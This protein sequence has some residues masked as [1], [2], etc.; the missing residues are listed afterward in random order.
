MTT[1]LPPDNLLESAHDP[2]RRRDAETVR[3]L[4]ERR[5][6]GLRRLVADYG[7]QVR[8]RLRKEFGDVM[9]EHL[10]DDAWSQALHRVWTSIDQYDAGIGT[11][12]AWFSTIA[13]NIVKRLLRTR[14]VTVTYLGDLDNIVVLPSMPSASGKKHAHLL[15]RLQYC[16]RTLPLLQRRV[17]LA[18]L[19][20]GGTAAA[21]P[22]AQELQTTV[23]TIYTSRAHARTALREA[24]RNWDESREADCPTVEVLE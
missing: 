15:D 13:G 5:E 19:A 9:D 22:L 20:A 1:V 2:Q 14:A 23:N 12:R 16:I 18:D 7:D 21:A 24:M 10:I 3:L 4:R 17:I 6:D 11:L 8:R